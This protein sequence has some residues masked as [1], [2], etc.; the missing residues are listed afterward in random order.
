MSSKE[1][2][3]FEK[4]VEDLE[5]IKKRSAICWGLATVLSAVACV[6]TGVQGEFLGAVV[7][8]LGTI[9]SPVALF[10][11][12]RELNEKIEKISDEPI[13]FGK[14]VENLHDQRDRQPVLWG[15]SALNFVLAAGRIFSETDKPLGSVNFDLMGQNIYLDTLACMGIGGGIAGTL[16]ATIRQKKLPGQI[17]EAEEGLRKQTIG[18]IV[19]CAGALE[20]H[21][22]NRFPQPR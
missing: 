7:T 20:Q 15:V 18:E 9:V 12:R 14:K 1:D 21:I 8:G 6:K 10:E 13:D 16:V 4:T 19:A 11:H 2:I 17:V 3:T 22:E 5:G